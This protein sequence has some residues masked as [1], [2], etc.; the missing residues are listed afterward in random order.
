MSTHAAAFTM[1]TQLQFDI[2]FEFAVLAILVFDYC[3]TFGTEVTWTWNRPWTFVRVL[4]SLARYLPFIVVPMFIYNSLSSISV[5]DCRPLVEAISWLINIAIMA[6]ECLL[7]IRTWVLCGRKQTVLV[8][9]IVTALGCFAVAVIMN[10]IAIRA[11]K[12]ENHPQSLSSCFEAFRPSSYVWSFLSLAIFELAILL[13]TVPQIFRYDRRSRI[14]VAMR[15]DIVYILFIFGMSVVNTSIVKGVYSGPVII[16]Q[17][18]IHSVLASRLL[19]SLRQIMQQQNTPCG[20]SIAQSS[21]DVEMLP[22]VTVKSQGGN[23]SSSTE[24][25]KGLRESTS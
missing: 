16:L 6:A 12:Y 11:I 20:E 14:F 5:A 7:L 4:L 19:F 2:Y 15:N 9:L 3:I 22:I 8:G 24:S 21:V 13:L 10:V 18:V 23:V 25:L 17:V 1:A